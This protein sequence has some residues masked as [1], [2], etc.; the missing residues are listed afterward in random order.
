MWS[1]EDV[2]TE[3]DLLLFIFSFHRY[4]HSELLLYLFSC[5][6]C[7]SLIFTLH[8]PE[9]DCSSTLWL[10]FLLCLCVCDYKRHES[11][12]KNIRT[13]RV[14]LGERSVATGSNDGVP[15]LASYHAETKGLW[16]HRKQNNQRA[17]AHSKKSSAP[18]NHNMIQDVTPSEHLMKTSAEKVCWII[19]NRWLQ[20]QSK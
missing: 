19:S 6:L 14:T 18:Q 20:G 7:H 17:G 4:S 16:N 3:K 1:W 15:W 10:L 9:G 8:I 5:H 13:Q 12:A 2:P 11:R